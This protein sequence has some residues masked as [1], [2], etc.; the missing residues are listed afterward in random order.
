M[1]YHATTDFNGYARGEGGIHFYFESDCVNA[2]EPG[3]SKD[4]LA[5]ARRDRA[6]WLSRLE[7]RPR[8]AAELV[9]AVLYDSLSS[10][11]VVSELDRRHAVT[12]LQPP[13]ARK[14]PG[15]SRPPRVAQR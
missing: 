8:H 10:V 1:P 13:E 15:G 14:T 11:P 4:V 7:V 3:L 9:K 12:K 5:A 6:R 2:L